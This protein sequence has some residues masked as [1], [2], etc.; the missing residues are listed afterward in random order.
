MTKVLAPLVHWCLHGMLTALL[1]QLVGTI[2][3]ELGSLK[4]LTAFKLENNNFEGTLPASL[5]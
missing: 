1:K 5:R 3:E 4:N 2:P